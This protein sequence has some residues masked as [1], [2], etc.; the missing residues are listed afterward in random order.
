[1]RF[2]VSENRARQYVQFSTLAI[3]KFSAFGRFG[4]K[5]S[6]PYLLQYFP[7]PKTFC[8]LVSSDNSLEQV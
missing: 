5:R 3:R 2:L 4:I 1:M 8:L 7:K 6:K